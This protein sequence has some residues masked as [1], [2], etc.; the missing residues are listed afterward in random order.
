MSTFSSSRL[1]LAGSPPPLSGPP[2]VSTV[3]ASG[4]LARDR[5]SLS[6]DC[7]A[8]TGA[9]ASS[10]TKN[11]SARTRRISYLRTCDAINSL[12]EGIDF[13]T[14]IIHEQR[15]VVPAAPCM[16]VPAA[17][18]LAPVT[19][20][21]TCAMPCLLCFT[22]LTLRPKLQKKYMDDVQSRIRSSFGI[23]QHC[24]QDPRGATCICAEI[25]CMTWLAPGHTAMS[26]HQSFVPPSTAHQLNHANLN[27]LK[28]WARKI[29]EAS[30]Q[31]SGTKPIKSLSVRKEA[32]AQALADHLGIDLSAPM[33]ADLPLDATDVKP[34]VSNIDRNIQQAQ[35]DL[36]LSAYQAWNNREP[37]SFSSKDTSAS[38]LED[39]DARQ[40]VQASNEAPPSAATT[41]IALPAPHPSS[42]QQSSSTI[43]RALSMEI[44]TVNKV[45]G[46]L[47]AI[48]H[49]TSGELDALE[50]KKK[51]KGAESYN[52]IKNALARHRRVFQ[53]FKDDFNSDLDCFTSFF[54]GYN[55]QRT[56][57][58]GYHSKQD[59]GLLS[60]NEV[61]DHMNRLCLKTIDK[62]KAKVPQ[63][64][65][66]GT[67][68][69]KNRF[70]IMEAI[71]K[72]LI[73]KEREDEKYL[74]D[75]IFSE[76][77]WKQAFPRDHW[78]YIGKELVRKQK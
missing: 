5:R 55:M 19:L 16:V 61:A 64:Q 28:F 18:R 40:A 78:Y 43:S 58:G 48:Q 50:E 67:W 42:I 44:S 4:L 13:Y 34:D 37:Y 57:R 76:K 39:E 46:L 41:Q 7:D 35:Y 63:D 9:G 29:N 74:E 27:E 31:L 24:L 38:A 15:M 49:G 22:P 1:A 30:M 20:Q 72:D 51:M 77:K 17:P 6:S 52:H 33:A 2:M 69:G 10:A 60:L 45:T 36:M 25:K 56:S 54:K 21:G 32:L 12:Y 66:D 75:G 3:A 23:W 11:S 71:W 26:T 68:E 73:K 70:E 62:E 53:I 8:R 59:D 47:E 65:W 14:S